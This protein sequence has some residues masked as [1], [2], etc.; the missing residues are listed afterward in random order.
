MSAL[1]TLKARIKLKSFESESLGTVYFKPLTLWEQDEIGL[2]IDKIPLA[3]KLSK[4]VI[5]KALDSK[6]ERLFKDS[7]ES[8]LAKLC[9]SEDVAEVANGILETKSVEEQLGE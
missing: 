1:D 3:K 2:G 4:A 6:G 9:S 5:M 8:D 7:E